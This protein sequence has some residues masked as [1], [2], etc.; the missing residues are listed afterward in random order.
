MTGLSVLGVTVGTAI[1]K[2]T[3][4]NIKAD[5]MVS[6]ANGGDLDRSALTALEKAEGVSAVSP[7]QDVYLQAGDDYVSASGITPGDIERVLN[8]DVVGG[9]AGTLAEGQIAVAEK[10]AKSKGWKPGD[11]IPFTFADEKKATLTVGAVYKDS[12]FLSPFSSTPP[13]WTGT[14]PSRTSGRSS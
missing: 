10:T 4:D 7:Q 11:R 5:Y 14:R 9:D 2:M 8:V 12:E 1:D 13:W 6:M 3:T